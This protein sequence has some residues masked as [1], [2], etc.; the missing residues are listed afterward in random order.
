MI[1]D[2]DRHLAAQQTPLNE[3][4]IRL[5]RI[6][7]VLDEGADGYP[8]GPAIDRALREALAIAAA[9]GMRVTY[10][11]GGVYGYA[12]IGEGEEML[13]ILGHLDVV[14]AGNL[15]DWA[16]G[17]F[18]PV[19]V[20]GFLYGRGT[21]DDKGPL[22]S[23]LFA[24]KALI[25]AGVT[26]N[27]RVRF[28]FGTDE[29][30]LWR[31]VKRYKEVEEWP[32]MGFTP[33][34]VFPLTFGEKG[35]LQFVLEGENESGV[36]LSG[37]TALNAVP[38]V[39]GYDGPGQDEL[40]D[41]LEL[42]EF[43][44][45][46]ED[47]GIVVLGRSAHAMAPED[48]VNAIIRLCIALDALGIDSGVAQ[49]IANEIGEDPHAIALLGEW[50]DELSGPLTINVG[51][52]DLDDVE[53]VSIDCRLPVTAS[54][55]VIVRRLRD[56]AAF[57]GL[58]YREYDWQAPIFLPL[59]HP[60]IVSLMDVYRRISGD[61]ETEPFVSGGATYAR[62]LDNCVAFGALM[63]DAEMTE[64][65]PNERVDLAALYQAMEIYA[66]AVYSLTR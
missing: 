44:F 31:C 32:R 49:F 3:A 17:P 53:R 34:S 54:K 47:G 16:T 65:Q 5:V 52:I 13:G 64:H 23:A 41:V 42:L 50:E 30:N 29:E 28:I 57:Y 62:A 9:L 63:P 21:Q 24:V 38:D 40:A 43:D 1:A 8:F 58:R 45:D 18:D 35:L 36:R 66:H 61:E 39:I 60:L 51:K 37:G 55:E 15:Q 11:D 22:L 20:D 2:L 4:L 59:D 19:E 25:D 14:P 56:A 48:G 26:F 33:D 10:G 27:R 12:E 7:S 46:R 6:P